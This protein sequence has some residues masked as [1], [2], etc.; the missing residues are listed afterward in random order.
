MEDLEPD[1]DTP[2]YNDE[3]GCM[4]DEN[5]AEKFFLKKLISKS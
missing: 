1:E 4:E 5:E 2:A 3:Y